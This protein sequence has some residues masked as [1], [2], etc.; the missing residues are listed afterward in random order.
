MNVDAFDLA[1]R[2]F[3]VFP[4]APGRK[5]PSAEG[6]QKSATDDPFLAADLIPDGANIGVCTDGL[7]VLDIDAGKGGLESFE[8]LKSLGVFP[9][10]FAAQSARGGSHYYFRPRGD[11]RFRS[12]AYRKM[13][14]GREVF[15]LEGFPGIDVRADGGLAVGPGSMFAGK[16][17]T[18]AI[19]APV[20]ELPDFIAELARAAAPRLVETPRTESS[21]PVDTPGAI[22][23][24]TGYLMAAEPAIEGNGGDPHTIVVANRCMDFGV[25]PETTLALMLE[26]WNDRCSPPWDGDDL[27]RKVM[28]AAKSRQ[29]PI[30]R[31]IFDHVF[32]VVPD[33]TPPPMRLSDLLGFSEEI[34]VDALI[35]DQQNDLLR[36][37]IGPGEFG[38]LYGQ[39]GSG[40]SFLALDLAWHVTRG[41]PWHGVVTRQAAVLYQM[42]EG[43]RGF[44]KRIKAIEADKGEKFSKRFA[45]VKPSVDLDRSDMGS[46]GTRLLIEAVRAL[47]RESGSEHVVVI[48]DTLARAMAG[49]DENSAQDMMHFVKQ[50]AGIVQAAAGAAVIVVHHPN[51]AGTLRGSGSLF[52]ASECILKVEVDGRRK[53]LFVEKAK[54]GPDH[55]T[56]FA[57]DLRPIELGRDEFGL[58]ANSCVVEVG[59]SEH[60]RKAAGVALEI[61]GEALDSGVL[62]SPKPRARNYAARYAYENQGNYDFTEADYAAALQSLL[63][64]PLA[65]DESRVKGKEVSRIIRR[66]NTIF[67]PF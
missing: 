4:L 17:Y 54:D 31:D 15:A 22:D 13:P 23:Q 63:A 6:W 42:G 18:I 40:K 10:T 32:D 7:F 41:E 3:R 8:R 16:P 24:A 5:Y 2:G 61:I 48:I 59:A 14:N 21:A 34:D 45:W 53:S 49:D 60:Q 57:Y 11:E 35:A 50:R 39:S 25:S 1:Y 36:N 51:K 43:H 66:D 46:E 28:S 37:M 27:H 56:L 62:L 38:V 19:D 30:G 29:T 64:G 33:F 65:A 26:H 52:G 44:K 12:R 9:E 20:A 47:Q 58:P 67:D 55:F